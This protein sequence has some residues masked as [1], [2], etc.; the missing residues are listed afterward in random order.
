MLNILTIHPQNCVACKTCEIACSYHHKRSFGPSIA[1]I[2]IRKGQRDPSF[3]VSFYGCN[4]G[5]HLP[6]DGCQKEDEP[7]CVK[8]C[9]PFAKDELKKLL[10][11]FLAER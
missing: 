2:E 11:E 3:A 4:H 5:N 8:Y 10:H 1:S 7:W 9:H 6:C